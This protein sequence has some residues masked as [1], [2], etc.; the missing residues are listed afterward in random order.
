MA[1]PASIAG[2]T[3]AGEEGRQERVGGWQAVEA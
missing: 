2:R 1:G 3:L